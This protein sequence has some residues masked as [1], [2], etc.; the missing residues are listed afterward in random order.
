MR[1]VGSLALSRA[2][3]S[4]IT[5]TATQ[6]QLHDTRLVAALDASVFFDLINS[7]G[8]M[9]SDSVSLL[10]DWLSPH[11]EYCIIET[12][13]IMRTNCWHKLYAAKERTTG[14]A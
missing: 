2:A 8:A 14:F 4:M 10:A 13:L 9:D 6:T 5:F 3:R 11:I 1:A 12:L 7:D